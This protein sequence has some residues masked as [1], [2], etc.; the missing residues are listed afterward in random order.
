MAN[1]HERLQSQ[2]HIFLHNEYP[3]LRG[4]FHANFNG[5]P[6]MLER[7]IP[8]NVKLRIMS[9]LK[10]VGLVKGVLDYELYH[11]G[12]LYMFDFKVG[13]DKLSKDQL[14]VGAALVKQGGAFCEI[15]SIEQFKEEI[16]SILTNGQLTTEE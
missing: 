16:Q 10:A 11:S 14:E 13:S 3:E 6:L 8:L 15:R 4:L 2:C 1:N 7:V 5:L 12:R 9:T